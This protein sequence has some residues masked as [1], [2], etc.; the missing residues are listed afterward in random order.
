MSIKKYY[1]ME[2]THVDLAWKRDGAEMAE[3]LEVFIVSLL[4][5]LDHNPEYKY[6]IE[7]A[8]HFRNLEKC[9]PDLIER[10]KVY[11]R[12]GRVE[13]VG[14]MASTLETNIPNG[15]SYVKNQV[16]GLKW[17]KENFGV[18]IKTGWLM[19]TFGINAQIPQILNQFGIENLMACRFGGRKYHQR[20]ISK[21]LDGSQVYIVGGD[22]YS[23][24][25]RPEETSS[26]CYKDWGYIDKTFSNADKLEGDG[27]FFVSLCTENEM[28]ISK[29]SLKCIDSRNKERENEEWKLAMPYEYF[30]A[31]RKA[32]KDWPI[33]DGDLNPEFTGTFSLR[34]IIRIENRKVE[35]LLLEAEKWASILSFSGWKEKLENSWWDMAY[36][37]FHDVFTGSHPTEV[38][39]KLMSIYENV[40]KAAQEILRDSFSAVLPKLWVDKDKFTLTTFNGLPWLRSDII[41][42]PMTL[43]M[44]GVSKVTA[45]NEDLTFEIKDGNLR[46]YADL[47][48]M[49]IKNFIIEKGNKKDIEKHEVETTTIEN[50]TI[51]IEFDNKYGI[52]RLVWKDTNETLMQ[53][54]GDFLVV[55][56]DNGNFQIEE[57][58]SAEVAAESGNIKVFTLD[59]S[60]L[61]QSVILSGEF[62][63]LHW[64]EE[65]NRL[66]WEAEFTLLKGKQRVDL[67]LRLHWKGEASRIRLKLSTEIDTSSGIYEIPFGTV[68]RKPYGVTETAR[69]EWPA[70]RFVAIEDK[71]HGIALINRGTVGVEVNGG[72]ILNTLIRAPKSEYAG[73]VSDDTSS[74]HGDHEFDFA[75]VPYAGSWKDAPV[76][77][78]AQEIN[79]PVHTVLREGTAEADAKE[80]SF[81]KLTPENLVL[82]AV[83][84][85]DDDIDE[86]AIRIY[87]TA[88]QAT[89]A[90]LFVKGCKQAWN[91]NLREEKLEELLCID[92]NIEYPVKAFEIKTIRIKRN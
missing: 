11:V 64:A 92:G 28:L 91:S 51:L 80:D 42:V 37:Q 24:Y 89:I 76:V 1:V 9:R 16:I 40:E 83:K 82:S 14:G 41:T 84:A 25:L 52:K 34:S 50:E 46:I 87:E 68:R 13:M 10:L 56:Q 71:I 62:P 29:H 78:A 36:N 49:G 19:D 81:I 22:V 15:E 60:E 30:N 4:D 18:D 74:Q 65:N 31:I 58:A 66:T 77:A 48:P 39:L 72:T 21:G 53:N 54:A 88:G 75:I 2:F 70:H 85:T 90:K 32:N 44:E 20:F 55:Q 43:A 5:G 6:V 7:Q 27:P 69:G 63:Q 8:A 86:L 67:K 47:P 35:N 61:G 17:V 59:P 3:M 79:N 12:Q 57:P 33:E 38:F 45:N 26:I 23:G 73:M